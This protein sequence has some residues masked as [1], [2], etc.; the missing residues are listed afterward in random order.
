MVQLD[1]QTKQETV[2]AMR[3]CIVLPRDNLHISFAFVVVTTV[4]IVAVFTCSV[5]LPSR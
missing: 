4:F 1:E 5:L 2:L 3:D